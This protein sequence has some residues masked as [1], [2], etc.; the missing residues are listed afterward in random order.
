LVSPETRFEA[1]E[2][3]AMHFGATST[4]PLTAGLYELPFAGAPLGLF[5]IKRRAPMR[6]RVPFVP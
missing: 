2:T 3:K 5:V 1:S 4:L 6:H